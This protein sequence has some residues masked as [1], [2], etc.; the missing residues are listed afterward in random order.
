MKMRERYA[1][2]RPRE[3]IAAK[4]AGALTDLELLTAII[5]RGNSAGD[6]EVLA[7]KVLKILNSD[8][9]LTYENLA[10]IPGLGAAKISELLA[11]FELARRR[12]NPPQ[13][14]IDAPEKAVEILSDIRG[15]NQEYFVELSLD[16]ANRL[17]KKRVITIGTLTASLV[18]PREVF[19]PAI[20]ERAAA[21][22]VAHNHPSGNLQPSAADNA[23]SERL[24]SAG[25]ILGINLLDHLILTKDS[26]RSIL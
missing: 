25:Q 9:A 1:G 26:W 20:A 16:G 8:A 18:H 10:K 22:I 19:A 23:V 17:I 6:V 24:K 7:R 11:A 5:G 13:N 4:G 14:L 2:D 15:K 3:K 21:I 12:L